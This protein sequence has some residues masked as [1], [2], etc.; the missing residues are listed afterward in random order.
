MK[1]KISISFD[2]DS[3][4]SLPHV[5]EY[6]KYLIN[7][8]QVEICICTRRYGP[9]TKGNPN[10]PYWTNLGSKN[11]ED[12]FKLAEEL[13][14]DKQNIIFCDMGKKSDFLKD[15]DFLWHLDD[16]KEEVDEISKNTKVKGVL[17]QPYRA[18]QWQCNNYIEEAL[19]VKLV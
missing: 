11:W 17:C 1:K 7:K 15:K 9:D 14:I 18:W 6:C 8:G 10:D 4:L 5:Q 16:F 3:T 12:V 2:F 13:K 19:N